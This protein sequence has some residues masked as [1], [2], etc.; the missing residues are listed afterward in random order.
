MATRTW[1]VT[2]IPVPPAIS[3]TLRFGT[4]SEAAR[5]EYINQITTLGAPSQT[6]QDATNAMLTDHTTLQYTD[7]VS[8]TR[9]I[10]TTVRG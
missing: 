10:L 7:P 3:T 4:D 8:G 2:T 1:T 6:I 9:V 5:T